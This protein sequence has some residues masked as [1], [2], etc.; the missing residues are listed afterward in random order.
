M[1]DAEIRLERDKDVAVITVDRPHARNALTAAM[2][3]RIIGMLDQLRDDRA[4]RAVLLRGAGG[5]AYI[6]GGDIQEFASSSVDDFLVVERQVE[7]LYEAI[8]RLP[9][10]V[11]AVVEGA[12]MGAGFMLAMSCDLCVCTPDAR[13]GVPIARL[14]NCLAPGEFRRLL[15]RVGPGRARDLLMRARALDAPTAC[16]WGLVTEVVARDALEARLG[17]L[18]AELRAAAPRALSAAKASMHAL[19][20]EEPLGTELLA[21]VLGSRDFRE[22]VA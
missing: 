8:E 11:V 16:A 18:T 1:S 22:G 3:P 7:A 6:A 15:A 17:E 21:Q 9:V 20:R 10:P 14:G 19:A 4:L 12:A 13:F 5:R 2:R